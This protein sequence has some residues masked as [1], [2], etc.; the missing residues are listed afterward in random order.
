MRF[1]TFLNNN[2]AAE[3]DVEINAFRNWVSQNNFPTSSMIETHV[4]FFLDKN[5]TEQERL[6]YK[7]AMMLYFAHNE[8]QLPKSYKNNTQTF[9]NWLNRI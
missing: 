2:L 7:K 1:L 5:L 4:L 3:N 8:N 9:L 6:G